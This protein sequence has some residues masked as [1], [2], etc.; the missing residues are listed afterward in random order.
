MVS[1]VSSISTGSNFIFCWNFLNPWMSVLYKN[2][3]NERFVF[4]RKNSNVQAHG[5]FHI[6]CIVVKLNGLMFWLLVGWQIFTLLRWASLF[7]CT[8][9]YYS[10]KNWWCHI[11]PKLKLSYK[12]SSVNR[13]TAPNCHHFSQW[14]HLLIWCYFINHEEKSW[15]QCDI[16]VF[17]LYDKYC[18]ILSMDKYGQQSPNCTGIDNYHKCLHL[19]IDHRSVFLKKKTSSGAQFKVTGFRFSDE[20]T[21]RQIAKIKTYSQN[22]TILVLNICSKNMNLNVQNLHFWVLP[23]NHFTNEGMRAWAWRAVQFSSKIRQTY[24]TESAC[25]R[26][27]RLKRQSLFSWATF[28][29]LRKKLIYSFTCANC[30]FSFVSY[31]ETI[32]SK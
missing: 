18:A 19:R 13:L 21:P 16:P 27:T 2:G 1:V 32:I 30:S 11:K 31:P 9:A 8:H 17:I 15:L 24:I 7:M 20:V 5:K 25:T 22:I 28:L 6:R 4:L 23:L 26:L 14:L 12:W 29:E 3:I 10:F